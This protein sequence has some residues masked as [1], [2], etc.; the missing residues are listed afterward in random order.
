MHSLF[1][2]DSFVP[3]AQA[4]TESMR[5]VPH[6]RQYHLYNSYLEPLRKPTPD[7]TGPTAAYYHLGTPQALTDKQGALALEMDYQA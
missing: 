4:H 1:E 2:P 6:W 5:K 3:L 7:P